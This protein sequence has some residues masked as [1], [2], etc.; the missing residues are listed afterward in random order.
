MG[1]PVLLIPSC[2]LLYYL[3]DTNPFICLFS[4]IEKG[5]HNR[6]RILS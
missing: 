6:K 1:P 4:A 3:L 2:K 5:R